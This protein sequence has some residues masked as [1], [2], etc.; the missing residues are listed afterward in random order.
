[1]VVGGY[2]IGDNSGVEAF[3]SVLVRR[4]IDDVI[5]EKRNDCSGVF[6]C[7]GVLHAPRA[8]SVG[9]SVGPSV[10]DCEEHATSVISLVIFV[11]VA[12]VFGQRPRQGTKSCRMGRNSVRTYIRP[13]VPPLALLAG[14]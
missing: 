14:P 11:D 2:G 9:W 5:G 8:G 4:G 6:R 1:M 7:K 12:A 3:E 10:A 13:S